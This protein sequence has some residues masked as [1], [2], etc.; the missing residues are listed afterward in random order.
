MPFTISNV[1]AKFQDYIYKIL[2]KK[3]NIF[4]IFNLDDIF[5]YKKKARDL[6]LNII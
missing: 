6:Y 1:L 4:L 3:L 2:V 5:I